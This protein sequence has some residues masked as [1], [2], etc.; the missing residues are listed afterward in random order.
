MKT[1]YD[2]DTKFQFRVPIDK[3]LKVNNNV[4]F[5]EEEKISIL[6]I[7]LFRLKTFVSLYDE[8]T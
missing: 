2:I 7:C 8:Y 6:K 5:T 1:H 3:E 4:F